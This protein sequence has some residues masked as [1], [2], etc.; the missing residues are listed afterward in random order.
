[1]ASRGPVSSEDMG[2][3]KLRITSIRRETDRGRDACKD[4]KAL[5]LKSTLGA[6]HTLV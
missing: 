4:L 3:V 1:M 2:I 5:D 6:S